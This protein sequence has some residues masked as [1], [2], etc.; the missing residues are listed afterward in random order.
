MS[1]L[2]EYQEQTLGSLLKVEFLRRAEGCGSDEDV[3]SYLRIHQ[4]TIFGALTRALRYSFPTVSKL[5]R[6]EEFERIAVSYARCH[7]P[8]AACLNIYGSGF[9]KYLRS[10]CT[11]P[12]AAALLFDVARFDLAV[13]EV[14]NQPLGVFRRPV[15]LSDNTVLRL[16]RSLRCEDYE[17]PV[18]RIR[19]VPTPTVSS[20]KV[21]VAPPAPRHLAIWR[22]NDGAGVKVLSSSSGRFLTALLKGDDPEHAIVAAVSGFDPDDVIRRLQREVFSRS[23]CLVTSY[24]GRPAWPQL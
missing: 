2:R 17:Y 11:R 10:I 3:P 9:P 22:R 12:S 8:T 19:D 18:D 6:E 24:R 16:D 15:V 21:A 13:Q 20:R 23:F 4:T 7:P 5:L 14:A 1:L